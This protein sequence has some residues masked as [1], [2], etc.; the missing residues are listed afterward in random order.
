M[1]RLSI[2]LLSENGRSRIFLTENLSGRQAPK[3][4]V[5]YR[6]KTLRIE[7]MKPIVSPSVFSIL[8]EEYE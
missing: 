1:G 2:F 7:S 3:F 5:A 4:L 6:L 8:E